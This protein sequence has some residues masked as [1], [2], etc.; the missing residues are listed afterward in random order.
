MF[1]DNKIIDHSPKMPPIQYDQVLV[2]MSTYL[3][4]FISFLFLGD[5]RAGTSAHI[6]ED[7]TV[8]SATLEIY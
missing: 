7:P 2:Y 4:F 3:L 1:T 8:D 5:K 6:S